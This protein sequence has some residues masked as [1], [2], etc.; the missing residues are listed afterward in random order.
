MNL[1]HLSVTS[2]KNDFKIKMISIYINDIIIHIIMSKKAKG[3]ED[4]LQKTRNERRNKNTRSSVFFLD[5]IIVNYL[6]E[7]NDIF[8]SKNDYDISYDDDIIVQISY[9]CSCYDDG[10]RCECGGIEPD[11]IIVKYSEIWNQIKSSKGAMMELYKTNYDIMEGLWDLEMNI[12]D[13][14]TSV[15]KQY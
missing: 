11:I 15:I 2:L 8:S 5:Q 10:V 4:Q 9:S 6:E 13:W 7:T 12:D 1:I 14:Y 3:K